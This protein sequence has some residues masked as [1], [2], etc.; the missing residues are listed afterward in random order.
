MTGRPKISVLLPTFRYARYL[1]EAID[2][3]LAQEGADF[4][5]V[6]S[7]DASGDGSAEIIGRYAGDPRVRCRI[8]ERNLGMVANWNWCLRQ[9][10]GPYVKFLFGDD[11]LATPR[12]LAPRAA[13]LAAA[14]GAGLAAAA[15]GIIDG[16]SRGIEIWDELGKAGYH[17]GTDVIARCALGNRNLVGE[18]TAVMF[19]RGPAERGFDP[20]WLQTVDQEMWFHLLTRGGLVYEPEPLCGFRIHGA[21][22]SA[23]NRESG[24]G[25]TESLL[26]LAR[27]LPTIAMA[28]GRPVRSFPV[29]RM[30]FRKVYYSRRH[31]RRL[32]LRTAEVAA[33]EQLL[34]AEL[35]WG[36][37]MLHWA[38]HRLTKPVVN[39]VRRLRPPRVHGHRPVA[40]PA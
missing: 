1:G 29:R 27:Y 40:G 2:S 7:D 25:V 19:R 12:S 26:L 16:D 3:V 18:P 33:A 17:A 31:S 13:L 8:Q 9:A 37:Y 35:S 38:A 39:L 20:Q 30:V 24:V 10:R 5:L 32:G 34:L 14:P 15:R 22:Q 11:R 6:I 28:I 36:W 23:A 21:Q 4:E